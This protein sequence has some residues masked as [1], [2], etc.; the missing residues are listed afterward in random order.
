MQPVAKNRIVS[1][2]KPSK[3]N[4]FLDLHGIMR[5]SIGISRFIPK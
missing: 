4:I 3:A 5:D 2:K 1:S